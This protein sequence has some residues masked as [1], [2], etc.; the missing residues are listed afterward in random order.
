MTAPADSQ[1]RRGNQEGGA[2]ILATHRRALRDYHV[3][4]RFEAG[5]ELRGAEVKSI[6]DN[7]FS[8]NES[9]AQI[10][11]GEVLL[12][13][14]HVLPYAHAR[15]DEQQS[16]RPKRLLLHRREIDRLLGQTALK[17]HTLVPLKIYL[18]RGLVKVELG[19]CRG[20]QNEDKRET[21]KRRTA[22]R[23]AE[24]A[25]AERTRRR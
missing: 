23:E 4:E 21:L 13:N 16:A 5:I 8:L 14:L 18:K 19:L 7:R 12:R 10:H 2:K 6:R 9:Y 20:K 22:E 1:P 15:A 17:G 25:I 3:L 24:R 11:D